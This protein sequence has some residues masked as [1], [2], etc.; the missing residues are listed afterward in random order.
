MRS[1]EQVSGPSGLF[2]GLDPD[3]GLTLSQVLESRRGLGGN[4][5]T[6][7]SRESTW[8]KFLAKFDEPIIHILLA[9]ALLSTVVDLFKASPLMGFVGLAV[10]L[11]LVGPGF[12]FSILR[13]WVPS[14][15]LLATTALCGLSFPAGHP[16]YEG[17]A[18]MLAVALATGVAF[19]SELQ[20]DREFEA[21][22][23]ARD[24]IRAKVRRDGRFQTIGIDE[25]VVGDLVL[26]EAGDEV[27][28]DGRLLTAVE[29]SVDQSLMTGESEPVH[30]GSGKS[31]DQSEGPEHP[32]CVYRGTQVV[33]GV[34]SLLA[35][36]VGD[37]TMV[38]QI[39]RS[40]AEEDPD[41]I[42][43]GGGLE[44]RVRQRLTV[45]KRAT[46]LQLKLKRLADT[47]TWAGYAAAGLIFSA[48]LAK[49][50]I[51]G[52]LRDSLSIAGA[53][54]AAIVYAVIIIVVAVP[55][56][57]P[58]SVTVSLA[59]A[60]RKMTR[61]NSLVRQ[62]VACE[63]IGSATVICSDKTGTLTQNRM[64]V[65]RLCAGGDVVDRG[66]PGW[67]EMA[68]SA[69]RVHEGDAAGWIALI[70]AVDS[71]AELEDR[72]G[73][74]V[75]VGN[76]TE[77]A[78][79]H[80]LEETK[81]DYATL[82]AQSPILYRAH[83]SSE[84]K[85]MSTVTR[86]GGRAVVLLK[87]A[88]E[89]VLGLSSRMLNPAG[90]SIPITSRDRERLLAEINR[91]AGDS[92]RTLGFAYRVLDPEEPTDIDG[93]HSRREELEKEVV[94]A[95][96][97]AI[98]DPLRDDVIGAVRS[99]RE[100]GIAVKMV[101]GDNVGTASAIGREIGLL[102]G[103]TGRVITSAEFQAMT[104][105]QARDAVAGLTILARA[106]PLDKLRLV[107]L[108]QERGEVVAVT[109]D[110]TNDAPALKRADV[111]L[112]MGVS[113][114]EVAKEA[115][116][117]V[118]L[119]DAFSTIVKAV[120]WG[121]ALYE[122]IQRFIQFQL[123]INIS[124]LVIAFAAPFMDIRPPFT[125]LQLLWINVIMDTLASIAL[126]SEPPRAGLMR[127]KPKARS[128]G[129]VTSA[130][131]GTIL[132][133]AA[134]YVAVLLALL[135]YMRGTPIAPGFL[136]ESGPGVSWMV[137]TSG[138]HVE[139]LSA[140]EIPPD[141][142][143]LFTM[144]QATVFF[145]VYVMFQVW[146]MFNCRSLAPGVSGISNVSANPNLLWVAGLIVV[147]QAVIVTFLGSLFHTEPLAPWDWVGIAVATSSVLV[148]GELARW[149]RGGKAEPTA[150]G[151]K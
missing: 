40:M 18:V 86:Q 56:G 16:S 132:G 2:P 36:E 101:T 149:I 29:M 28:A 12:V 119:D 46:P 131:W 59:M 108:L 91:S 85:R 74:R 128:E 27:P 147:F 6:P 127:E 20:S 136:G 51:D 42:E 77:G 100:A 13:S 64:T 53:L 146:N 83:F 17:L 65:V 116:K 135:W 89:V 39:A 63:T 106:R 110:G 70:A 73:R 48:M 72:D 112:A 151:N 82:R 41:D 44:S 62:L 122:N 78:L 4:T 9:A 34:G 134:F 14:L 7:V 69:Q 1:I 129:I 32:A 103:A 43:K 109:G 142:K 104:D 22:N 10:A 105:S 21:L 139:R 35:C 144:R 90:D 84:R 60:M 130:M 81:V 145:T 61:A 138:G 148:F 121:R 50:W 71:T 111:G 80:W 126:C 30:K 117:I 97:V 49:S 120:H 37:S 76:G 133:T 95:G 25:I 99:C 107:R 79:L 115:S 68:R 92:M 31:A 24:R 23:S 113:G 19:L 150:N 94:F 45:S 114:T 75:V 140:D 8:R 15:I 52:E 102:D 26:L 38:G 66:G 88:S 143:A 87:G 54:L 96:F 55:E 58:M 3:R 33:D 141:G 124:A 137:E 11:A 67:L 57:L 125:V 98:Q 5:L 93:L 47:I 123:T 118:L